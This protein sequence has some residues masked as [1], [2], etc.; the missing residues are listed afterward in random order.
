MS[1]AQAA[2]LIAYGTMALVL[3]WS[4]WSDIKTERVPNRVTIPAIFAGIVYWVIVG[5]FIEIGPWEAGKAALVTGIIAFAGAAL[6]F[7]LGG[8][9]GADVKT[10]TIVGTWSASSMVVLGTVV[11]A[12]IFTILL[13]I[14]TAWR[15]GMVRQ[16]ITRLYVAIM[17]LAARKPP[18][19]DDSELKIPL[20]VGIFLGCLIAGAE[21][22]LG[23]KLP[24]TG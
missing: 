11:Y 10:L 22:M 18:P 19:L 14:F 2:S 3:G 5:F 21:Y 15:H 17:T 6:V 7:I 20:V 4:A 9:G 12:M 24:W 8:I 16:V 13:A 23:W 1:N